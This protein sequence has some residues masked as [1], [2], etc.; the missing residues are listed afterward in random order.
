MNLIACIAIQNEEILKSVISEMIAYAKAN[1]F[2][3]EAA[4]KEATAQGGEKNG[5]FIVAKG[6]SEEELGMVRP[7]T[8]F[9]SF[10]GKTSIQLSYVEFSR[11]IEDISQ[12]T[13]VNNS[14]EDLTEEMIKYVWNLFFGD[15]PIKAAQT[16]P[17]VFIGVKM[18]YSYDPWAGAGA[19]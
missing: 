14:R 5:E 4:I 12:L 11:D 9:I 8:K 7:Y 1:P 15:E 13:I 17:H 6:K 16:P 10:D 19:E 2:N 3:Y 18:K